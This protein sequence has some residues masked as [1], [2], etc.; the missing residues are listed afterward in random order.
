[1]YRPCGFLEGPFFGLKPVFGLSQ[2]FELETGS[3]ATVDLE[4][5]RSSHSGLVGLD[6]LVGV[7]AALASATHL[8]LGLRM[9]TLK[10]HAKNPIRVASLNSIF[11]VFVEASI[12]SLSRS[13]IIDSREFRALPVDKLRIHLAINLRT[14]SHRA[15]V[16]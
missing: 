10:I 1:M 8:P 4:A 9:I 11:G 7:A 15:N 16:C 3:R 2:D 13:Q 14:D 12:G 5:W 6:E